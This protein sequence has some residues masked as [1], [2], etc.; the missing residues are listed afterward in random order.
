MSHFK[1][2][3]SDSSPSEGEPAWRPQR[4]QQ[5]GDVLLID[6]EI[7]GDDDEFPPLNSAAQNSPPEL[8]SV[9]S[10]KRHYYQRSSTPNLDKIAWVWPELRRRDAICSEL[11]KTIRFEKEESS[12]E[13][14]RRQLVLRMKGVHFFRKSRK[15]K[16]S[17][18]KSTKIGGIRHTWLAPHA[19]W[20]AN[21][22]FFTSCGNYKPRFLQCSMWW[23]QGFFF[24]F[25]LYGWCLMR[26][27][28]EKHTIYVHTVC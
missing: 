25:R 28:I 6:L 11:E 18:W 5:F 21:V 8:T 22:A 14:K 9:E 23:S 24:S 10:S 12:L 2:D 16:I 1:Q 19:R 13:E 17:G 3:R 20:T 4:V 26:L 7:E 15:V 27:Q